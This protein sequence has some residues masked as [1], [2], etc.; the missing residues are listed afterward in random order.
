MRGAE[1]EEEEEEEEGDLNARILR[2]EEKRVS[3]L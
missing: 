3:A 2:R 1:E